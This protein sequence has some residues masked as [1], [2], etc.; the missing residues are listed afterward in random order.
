MTQQEGSRRS[1]RRRY[2]RVVELILNRQFMEVVKRIR[3]QLN[4]DIQQLKLFSEKKIIETLEKSKRKQYSGTSFMVK[5]M[6]RSMVLPAYLH[7]EGQIEQ[8]RLNTLMGENIYQAIEG[9]YYKTTLDMFG[10]TLEKERTN[11][12]RKGIEITI[13][14]LLA[15]VLFD[16]SA[17]TDKLDNDIIPSDKEIE[18]DAHEHSLF[19]IYSILGDLLSK[20][21]SGEGNI[22]LDIIRPTFNDIGN[23]WSMVKYGREL[24]GAPPTLSAPSTPNSNECC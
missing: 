12:Q 22:L 18:E 16:I 2:G 10:D 14:D 11:L 17:F 23:L 1:F 4:I 20:I 7:E 13:Y 6:W 5:V 15:G 9:K 24:V 19:I 3:K 21:E 8:T